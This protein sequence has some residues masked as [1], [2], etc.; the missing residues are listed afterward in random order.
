M[1][2]ATHD[3]RGDVLEAAKT[4]GWSTDSDWTRHGAISDQFTRG[5]LTLICFWSQTPWSEARWDGGV[6]AG[7]DGPRQVWRIEGTDGVMA[8]LRN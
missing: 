5:K 4:N 1:P 6:L 8:I 3:R 2:P 7:P